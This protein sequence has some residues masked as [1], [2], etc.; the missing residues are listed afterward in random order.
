MTD[1]A[2]ILALEE[3][4]I[5]YIEKYGITDDARAYFLKNRSSKDV[6]KNGRSNQ[7]SRQ[8]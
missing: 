2:K 7:S 6:G 3:I 1:E 5:N 4:V 8:N